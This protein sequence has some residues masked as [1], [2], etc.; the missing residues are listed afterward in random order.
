M[1]LLLN[2]PSDDPPAATAVCPDTT[3]DAPLLTVKSPLVQ[4]CVVVWAPEITVWDFAP[5]GVIAASAAV[6]A[7][8]IAVSRLAAG[9]G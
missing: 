3:I 2:V 5:C 6:T 9:C 7:R 1:P 4:I 8:L